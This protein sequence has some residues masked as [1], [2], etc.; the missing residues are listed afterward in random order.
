LPEKHIMVALPPHLSHV[1]QAIDVCWAPSFK[2]AYRR[3]LKAHIKGGALV[4]AYSLLGPAARTGLRSKA[5]DS[6]V[7]IA[8]AVVDAATTAT[9]TSLTSDAFSA[10]GLFP[11]DVRK[12][13][14]SK[15]VRA[16]DDDVE[17]QREALDPDQLHT[18]SRV[19]TAPAFL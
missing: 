15:C 9:V 18:G 12:P 4:R 6:R 11:V 13:L 5:G 7:S 19:L 10:T 8:F 14:G 2:I 16:C 1:M 17:R 3:S